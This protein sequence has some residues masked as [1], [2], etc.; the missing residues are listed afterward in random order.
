M[1][2][3]I[4]CPNCQT[5]YIADVHQIVDVGLNPSLKQ[6]FLSGQLN[7]AQCPSC[8]AVTQVSTPLLYHDP[9]HEIFTVYVPMEMGLGHNDQEKLIGQLVKQAMDN[10]PPE[11]RRGYMF[12]PQTVLS[13]QTLMEKVLETEGVT[14]EMIARQRSQAELLETLVTAD[15]DVADVLIKERVDEIDESFFILLR[16]MLEAAENANREEETLKLINLQAKLYRETEYGRRLERQ[17]QAL[18]SFSRDVNQAG[19]LNQK[20]LL[21]HVIANREDD[22]VISALVSSGQQ[23]FD[24]EFFVQLSEKIDKR[25]KAGID[26][27]ELVAL[28]EKLLELQRSMEQRSREIVEVAQDTLKKIL[29][30]DDREAAVRSHLGEMDDVFMYVLSANLSQAE[31]RGDLDYAATLHQIQDLV[32]QEMEKQAPPELRLVNQLIRAE[33]ADEQRELLAENSNLV[34]PELLQIVKALESEAKGSGENS[35]DGRL[36][37]VE[38]M[39]E[40][41]LLT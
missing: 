39:I 33:N 14:P 16:T 9:E 2:T 6:I 15:Q 10:L 30:A 18:R 17:Q 32:I 40:A 35:L 26:A 28:R 25:E 12:Q 38:A 21:K 20:L 1:Q 31:Q 34:N 11:Q 8:Q 19:E 36:R 5:P 23:A 7:I 37:E 41:Q 22:M 13:M 24:Y 27:S 3:Q 29:Q 4:T